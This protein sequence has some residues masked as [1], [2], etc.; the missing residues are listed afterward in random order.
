MQ[1]LMQPL[2]Q[3]IRCVMGSTQGNPKT[4]VCPHSHIRSFD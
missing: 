3:V 1:P 2:L 4:T